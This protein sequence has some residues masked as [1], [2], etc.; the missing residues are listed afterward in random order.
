MDDANLLE[1]DE[2]EDEQ[3][4]KP[5]PLKRPHTDLRQGESLSMLLHCLYISRSILW[6]KS[7]CIF[8]MAH[9]IDIF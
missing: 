4:E 2:E 8:K 3:W 7:S 5:L 9:Q 1:V 6:H